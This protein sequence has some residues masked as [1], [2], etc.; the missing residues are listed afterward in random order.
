MD[1][2]PGKGCRRLAGQKNYLQTR[3]DLY[4]FI[5]FPTQMLLKLFKKQFLGWEDG[6]I[7]D[8]FAHKNENITSG[9]QNQH[10]TEYGIITREFQES[11]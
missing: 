9:P 10:K 3:K 11:H 5:L 6:S 7:D 2:D 4:N 8:L 1:L